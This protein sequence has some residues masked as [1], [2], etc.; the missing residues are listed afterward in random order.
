[1]SDAID[2]GSGGPTKVDRWEA[3][4]IAGTALR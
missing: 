2:A 4:R 1:M 3:T